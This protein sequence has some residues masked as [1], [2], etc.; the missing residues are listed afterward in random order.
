MQVTAKIWVRCFNFISYRCTGCC[1]CKHTAI[2][3][4]SQGADESCHSWKWFKCIFTDSVSQT[5][6][7]FFTPDSRQEMFF[8]T[9]GRLFNHLPP[10]WFIGRK[11]RK[12]N[13]HLNPF[14]PVQR[15]DCNWLSFFSSAAGLLQ[16]CKRRCWLT[17]FRSVCPLSTMLL[18]RGPTTVTC[19]LA[20]SPSGWVNSKSRTP[21][22]ANLCSTVQMFG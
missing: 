22:Q 17:C 5:R 20:P 2:G 13:K 16:A 18:Y 4:N 9:S 21:C 1:C 12:R 14:L 8:V 15:V 6:T 7:S 19:S 11:L 3:R 10:C